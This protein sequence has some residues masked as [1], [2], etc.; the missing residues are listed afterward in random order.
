[1]S[2]RHL[3]VLALLLSV[4]VN[5]LVA[6]VLI[7]RVGR[8]PHAPPPMDWA[9][10]ELDAQTRDLVRSRLRE[11]QAA[12]RPLR[13]EMVHATGAVRAAISATDYDPE[14]LAAALAQLRDVT[15]RYQKLAH[16]NLV[17]VSAELPREQRMA[18]LRSALQRG[19]IDRRGPVEP[20]GQDGSTPPR[21]PA[22]RR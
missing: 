4:S 15:G 12:F 11:Q 13:R 17:N 2:K 5:L 1:M 9:G 7:G 8:T 21:A 19:Q 22:Q 10:R 20:R 16:D 6:G 18:L 3:L 14:V